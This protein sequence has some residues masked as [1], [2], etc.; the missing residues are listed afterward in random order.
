MAKFDECHTPV[1]AQCG[2]RLTVNCLLL[3]RD[4]HPPAFGEVSVT[5]G[6]L[7]WT[8]VSLVLLK[9]TKD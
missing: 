1:I 4:V 2:R 9:P 5:Q 3:Q 8:T 6:C 7:K